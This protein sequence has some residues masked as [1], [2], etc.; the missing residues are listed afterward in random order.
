M[1][2]GVVPPLLAL[3]DQVQEVLARSDYAIAGFVILAQD[4]SVEYRSPFPREVLKQQLT[5]AAE[6]L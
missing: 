5:R 1:A 2:E 4:G 3:A 6:E